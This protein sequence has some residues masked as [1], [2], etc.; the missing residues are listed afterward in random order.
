MRKSSN[1]MDTE[2]KEVID[3]WTYGEN[4]NVLAIVPFE[5]EIIWLGFQPGACYVL[6]VGVLK[7][8]CGSRDDGV[9]DGL[10]VIWYKYERAV[11]KAFL[12]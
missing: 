12:G 10:S 5:R 2:N 8:R 1:I 3:A 9:I 7:S 6:L 4:Q 11:V